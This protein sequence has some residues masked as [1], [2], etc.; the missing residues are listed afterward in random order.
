MNHDNAAIIVL[1]DL[2]ERRPAPCHH[3]RAALAHPDAMPFHRDKTTRAFHAAQVRDRLDMHIFGTAG[4]AI[5]VLEEKGV[6][7][8]SIVNRN[9]APRF[10]HGLENFRGHNRINPFPFLTMP[11]RAY[12]R[13]LLGMTM[14]RGGIRPRRHSLRLERFQRR[15]RANLARDDASEI[16]FHFHFRDLPIRHQHAD[17]TRH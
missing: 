5:A 8:F 11:R 3:N 14:R 10:T 13:A 12:I 17:R 9:N 2:L 4:P 16:G 7:Q 15:I 6:N 1:Q